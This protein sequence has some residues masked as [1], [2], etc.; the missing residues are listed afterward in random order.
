MKS[1]IRPSV[2][3]IAVLS[4]L[5]LS[6]PA[7]ADTITFTASGTGSDGALAA[8]AVFTTSAGVLTIQLTN[9]LSASQIVSAGQ[10]LSDISFTLSGTPGTLGTTSASGQLG[11]ISSTGAV[12]YTS[13][14]PSRWLGT[15]GGQFSIN[16]GNVTLEAIGG[17]QPDQMIAPFLANG[18]T[19][20]N[21]NQ[22]VQN[23]NPFVIGSAT[24]TINLSGVTS[25]TTVSNVRFSFGTGPDTFL[26]GTPQVPEPTSMMLLGTGLVGLAGAVRRKLRS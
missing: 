24:F 8:S 9:F 20:T 4:L 3:A 7:W 26:P 17:G 23:F 11:N 15:G 16:G 12:A 18:G 10:F 21:A 6:S 1:V 5:L 25:N 22:G 2:V 19:F 14:S 13:G